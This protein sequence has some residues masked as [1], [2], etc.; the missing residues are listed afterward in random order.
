VKKL[1]LVPA[2]LAALALAGCGGDDE[3]D[4]VSGPAGVMPA[5]SPVY[6]EVAIRPD[7]EQAEN[8]D[9]FLQEFSELPL[10]GSVGDPRD[11]AI[12][13]LEN[14]A[15][16]AGVDFSYADD[17][18]PWLGER[19][20]ISVSPSDEGE[21]VVV[22]AIETTDEEQARESIE[23]LL[24]QGGSELSEEEYEGVSYLTAPDDEFSFGVFDGNVVFATTGAFESAVDASNEDSLGSSDKFAESFE[25]L[26]D[27]SLGSLY[28]DLAEIGDFAESPEEAEEFEQAQAVVPEIFEGAIGISAGLSAGNQIYVDYSTPMVEGQPESGESEL[29]A[30]A[31]DDALGVFA[32]EDV[33]AY[34][35]PIVDILERA[36]EEGADLED[37]PEEGL[38]Q[39]FE[40]ETDIPL[41]DA[42][43]AFGD[44]SLWVRGDLP[45]G[46]EVGGE[47]KAAV[48]EIAG[49]MIERLDVKLKEEGEVEVGPPVDGSEVGFSAQDDGTAGDQ[50]FGT[51]NPLDLPGV[52]DDFEIVPGEP[53]GVSVEPGSGSHDLPFFNVALD[54]DESVVRYGFF[55]DKQAAEESDPAS[56]GDFSE[57][58]T[59]ASGQEAIGDDFEY[60]GAIDLAPIVDEYAPSPG[61]EDAIL[62]PAELVAPF[63]ASKLGVIAFGQRYEGDTAVTRYILRLD[64]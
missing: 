7:G 64:D 24:E 54:Q 57:T 11:F 59:Y 36:E 61:I 10:I 15:E 27:G 44:L 23:G 39:A 52:K 58:E 28:V 26:A 1:S 53:A 38:A 19:M 2:A 60:L 34:V 56:A 6:F 17:I 50:A 40:N 43:E 8:L 55:R 42:A 13:Q 33:G 3:S 51:D 16:S 30:S 20:G 18:E 14:E 48:P 63:L 46:L 9:A 62:G 35:A 22:A 49:D 25:S 21:E 37:F 41:E 32:L 31:P 45:D 29:L 5:G 12:E 4:E 47:I